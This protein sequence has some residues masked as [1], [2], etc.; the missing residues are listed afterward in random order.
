[1][2]LVC[3]FVRAVLQLLERLRFTFTPNGKREFV[4]RGQIFPLIVVNCLLLQPKN[5]F[6][7]R[8]YT[9]ELFWT[10]FICLFPILRNSQLESDVCRLA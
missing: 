2:S 3:E 8:F 10:V 7:R 1:M 9:K 5:K 4:P 6:S